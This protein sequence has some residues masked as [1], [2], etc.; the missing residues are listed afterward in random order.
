[1]KAL[2]DGDIIVYQGGFASDQQKYTVRGADFQYKKDAV[3]HAK[4]IGFDP[5]LIKKSITSE[6]VA[7][8]LHSIKKMI[9]GICHNVDATDKL[10]LLSG[11]ANF[12]DDLYPAYKANRDRTQKPT[13]YEDIRQYLVDVHKA[14]VIVGSEADD[15]LGWWQYKDYI[16]SSGDPLKAETCICTIDKDL[17]QVPGWHFNWRL[18]KGKGVM[19]WVDE[20][21]ALHWFFQQWLVGDTADNIPGVPGIGNKTAEKLMKAHC[22]VYTKPQDYY[23]YVMH[24]WLSKT[25]NTPAFV[26]MVGDLLWMQRVAGETWDRHLGLTRHEA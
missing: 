11:K 15:A 4:K 7:H 14:D 17:D 21:D 12:R 22:P 1:M 13:H 18:D 10:I 25:S 3:A 23:D 20:A 2:V 26:N 9:E 19:Y 16:A 6:P 5:A 24:M 8:C